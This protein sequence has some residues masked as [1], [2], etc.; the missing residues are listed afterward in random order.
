MQPDSRDLAL[1]HLAADEAALLDYCVE[2]RADLKAVRELLS[3]ALAQL[4]EAN[5]T[6]H[7]LTAISRRQSEVIRDWIDGKRAA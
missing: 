4:G 5:H 3:V 1:E 2:L 6:I 7:R